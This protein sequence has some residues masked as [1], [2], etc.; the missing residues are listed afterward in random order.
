MKERARAPS[1]RTAIGRWAQA[2]LILGV[3]ALAPA[4]T[5]AQEIEDYTVAPGDS[6]ASIAQRFYGS[7]RRYDRIHAHNPDLGPTPHRLRP[8]TVLHLPL[9][10]ES[11]ADATVTDARGSVRRQLPTDTSWDGARIGDELDTGSRVSTGERSSAE[12]TFRTSTVAAIR[13]E[14]LVIVHGGSVQSAREEGS[15]AVLREGSILARLSSLSEGAPPLLVETPE[16]QLELG[17]GETSLRARNGN[18]SVSVHHGAGARVRAQGGEVAVGAGN[19]TFVR[20]GAPPAPPR[21]LPSPPSWAAG[22]RA[23][24]G[25][26]PSG[27]I[28]GGTLSG[29]W[30]PVASA[31]HYRVEIA[32]REDGRDLVFQSD[33]PA[34]VTQFE[35]HGLPPGRY[36]VRVA[37]YDAD[38]L[39]GRPPAPEAFE[40]I[41][42]RLLRPGEPPPAPSTGLELLEELDAVGDAALLLIEAPPTPQVLVGT[43][44]L[45]P[46]GVVCAIGASEPSHDLVLTQ[47]GDGFLTCIDGA[48]TNI[49][50]MHVGVVRL[51]AR[52][53]DEAGAPIGE[54]ARE[55]P[56]AVRIA[57]EAN[58]LPLAELA[59][60]ASGGEVSEPVLEGETLR[61]TLSPTASA[62]GPITL[63]FAAR[64]ARELVLGTVEIAV[65]APA[66]PIEEPL[67]A[68][69]RRIALHEGLGLFAMPSWVGLRDEQRTGT[70][71]TIGVMVASARLG[72]RDPRLRLIAGASA[73]L[74]EEYLRLSASAPLDVIGQA[75]RSADRGARDLYVSIGSRLA[76]TEDTG[77]L[78]L[79][80]ELGAWA[81]TAAR[82]GLD[83]AR[84][85]IAADA[86]LRFL[87]RL[88]LRTRQAGIFDLVSAPSLL[89]A[90]AWGFDVAIAGPLTAGLE[91]TMTIGRE[92]GRDWY[93][94][95]IGIGV[96]IDLAPVVISFAGRYGFGDDLWPEVS[97]AMNVRASFDP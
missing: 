9:P 62:A 11:G 95:G 2:A 96:G 19:G 88:T 56:T 20:R 44:V 57:I 34:S 75:A 24:L 13:A 72:E 39:E 71:G 8:G 79:A 67:P 59:V 30:L 12:L 10:H 41:G 14:T 26:Y 64:S 27:E 31:A 84:L 5:S 35:A 77:G 42:A 61:T 89:Y 22:P 73:G 4:R 80:L 97:G 60:A 6:C 69:A 54:I 65:E 93:A 92:D 68:P 28:L 51:R 85:M 94:G 17:D 48:G 21:P 52:V 25:L 37:T 16:A 78:G 70:G 66:A 47:E 50:G 83:R 58:D 38:W 18:S 32:R 63:A 76:R 3:S 55:R 74:F 1:C 86:S 90:S 91:G 7:P 49:A 36:F 46:D 23:F 29:S 81:P 15:R 33:V 53:L 43:R 45:V 40:I 87:D 82:S